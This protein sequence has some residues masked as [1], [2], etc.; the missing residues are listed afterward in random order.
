MTGDHGAVADPRRRKRVTIADIA[1]RAGVTSGAVSIAVNGKR[2]VSDATRARILEVAKELHWRPS[3]A[4]QTLMG[5]NAETIGLVLSRPEEVIGEEIFF[6]KFIAGV[7]SVLSERGY[8]LQLQMAADIAAE[9]AIH[10][11]WIADGRV[12]GVLVLDPRAEDPRLKVLAAL[13]HPTIVVGGETES[14][15]L[16]S[17]H[18]D[19]A[20]SMRLI[21]QHLFDLGHTR[22]AYVSGDQSFW[23]T[24]QRM[25]AFSAFCIDNGVWG[26]TIAGNFDPSLAKDATRRLLASP[27][28]PTA[29]VYDSDVMAIAG[30]S[31][32]SGL[33]VAVPAD[34]SVVSWEDS[35]TCQVLHPTLTALNRDAVTLGKIAAAEM[36]Q[37]LAHEPV[38]HPPVHAAI[39]HR[40]STAAPR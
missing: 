9:I 3:H 6:A 18:V 33:G 28:P 38:E 15:T 8:S 16:R 29:L 14:D 13:G 12:D 23:H 21:M 7:Q 1:E 22:I 10:E 40:E 2:G 32:L 26:Q 20:G 37:L 35:T 5:K 17:V 25:D 11:N 27:Q 19:N 4:A 34:V 39:V 30:I 31:T 24:Q 36:L